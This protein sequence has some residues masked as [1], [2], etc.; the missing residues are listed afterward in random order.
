VNAAGWQGSR[1]LR[2]RARREVR[3]CR[4]TELKAAARPT[5]DGRR[6]KSCRTDPVSS[7][8]PHH[9]A[10]ESPPAGPLRRTRDKVERRRQQTPL[11]AW[12]TVC[13]LV[14]V[15]MPAGTGAAANWVATRPA[16]GVGEI[17]RLAPAGLS[18]IRLM[19]CRTRLSAQ[20]RRA[21]MDSGH[22]SVRPLVDV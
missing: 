4:W 6:R 2:G 15:G 22:K 20:C 10:T 18:L 12:L 19:T 14:S 7:G 8:H 9:G 13:P 16:G 3:S 1:R 21:A 17:R 5:R 11:Y